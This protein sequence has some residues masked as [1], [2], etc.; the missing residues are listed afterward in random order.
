MHIEEQPLEI[1][2]CLAAYGKTP[3][4]L[5]NEHLDINPMFTAVHCTHTAAADLEEYIAAGGNVCINPLTEGNLGDGIPDVPRIL[6]SQG[7]IAL[8]SD[9]NA[10]ICWTEEMRWLEYG[11]RLKLQERGICV[12]ESA[13]VAGKLL[14][15]ATVNGAR[16]LGLKAGRLA[17]KHHAD[18]ALIDLT[19][20]QLDGWT[21]QTLLD[22]LVFGTGNEAIAGVCVAG[23]LTVKSR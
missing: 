9:S 7:R 8:G 4:A 19:A 16:C 6:K 1:E 18:F 21:D 20:P 5:L 12:D 3:M 2:E 11:Q 23:R 10:R 17:P 14:E 13:S 22:S 15:A